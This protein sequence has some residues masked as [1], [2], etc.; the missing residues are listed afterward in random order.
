M[1]KKN[2]ILLIIFSIILTGCINIE[3][4]NINVPVPIETQNVKPEQT[5]SEQIRTIDNSLVSAEQQ[6]NEK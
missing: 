6:V 3:K 2:I 5:A 4:A 1:I